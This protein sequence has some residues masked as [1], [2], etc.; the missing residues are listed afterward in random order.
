MSNY[1]D[2]ERE[3][4]AHIRLFAARA[5][6]FHKQ[7]DR[8]FRDRCAERLLPAAFSFVL[9]YS[10]EEVA[11]MGKVNGLPPTATA[12]DVVA[13]FAFTYADAMVRARNAKAEGRS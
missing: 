7:Q 1:P 12:P 8:E 6:A 13:F 2:I 11:K 3:V 9:S 4:D 10:I 5:E